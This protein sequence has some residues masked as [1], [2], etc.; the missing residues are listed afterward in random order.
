M[1]KEIFCIHCK[2]SIGSY[3]DIERGVAIKDHIKYYHPDI[4]KD[5][6][7]RAQELKGLLTEFNDLTDYVSYRM[8]L[9]G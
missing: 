8:F 3:H 6:L 1:K 7:E 5:L 4:F 9:C 2:K